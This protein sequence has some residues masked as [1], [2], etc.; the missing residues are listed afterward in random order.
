MSLV[1]DPHLWIQVFVISC[2]KAVNIYCLLGLRVH[3]SP[4]NTS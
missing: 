2:L 1:L 4:S 3:A